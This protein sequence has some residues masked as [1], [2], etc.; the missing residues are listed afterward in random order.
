MND[1]DSYR[2]V[3]LN[4]PI[5]L[6]SLKASAVQL[7]WPIGGIGVPAIYFGFKGNILEMALLFVVCFVLLLVLYLTACILVTKVKLSDNVAAS[8]YS[9]LS[10]EE[11]GKRIADTLIG[12]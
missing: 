10:D 4:F 11:K 6:H 2:N 3:I 8:E 9:S 7:I 5:L 1:K 12:W